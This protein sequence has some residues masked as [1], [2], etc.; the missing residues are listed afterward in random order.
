MRGLVTAG[1][2]EA[3]DWINDAYARIHKWA[4]ETYA[5]EPDDLW[6]LS[7]TRAGEPTDNR[8]L[9]MVHHPRMLLSILKTVE[10]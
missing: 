8:K 3:D 4:F 5:D 1:E 7:V 6:R 2:T 10:G 9:D